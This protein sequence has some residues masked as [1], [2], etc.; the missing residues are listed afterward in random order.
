MT[1][2]K[3]FAAVP[4]FLL[5]LTPGLT[6]AQNAYPAMVKTVA[7]RYVSS[8][9][10]ML[11]GS[12]QFS[13]VPALAWFEYGPTIQLGQPTAV[14]SYPAGT[15]GQEDIA[16]GIAGLEPG[17]Q[18]Y[19]RLVVQ[20]PRGFKTGEILSFR[21]ASRGQ[22]V[23]VLAEPINPDLDSVEQP[24]I[25]IQAETSEQIESS[26]EQTD[27]VSEADG[28]LATSAASP[29]P[30]NAQLLSSFLGLSSIRWTDMSAKTLFL[31]VIMAILLLIGGSIKVAVEK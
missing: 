28:Q 29:N 3:L 1:T 18:Y 5:S 8:E 25:E 13:G 9:S 16:T 27:A 24:A 20:D 6:S 10:A 21:T 4:I 30:T 15:I 7:A 23:V 31:I 22:A 17:H 26:A 19:F 14:R 12:L 11:V 2:P